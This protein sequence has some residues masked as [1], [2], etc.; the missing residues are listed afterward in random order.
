M[1]FQ[2]K[3]RDKNKKWLLSQH[4]ISKINIHINEKL[5]SIRVHF[6]IYIDMSVFQNTS[7][8]GSKKKKKCRMQNGPYIIFFRKKLRIENRKIN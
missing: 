3:T 6:L 1:F 5:V 2:L 4:K 8:F 7:K